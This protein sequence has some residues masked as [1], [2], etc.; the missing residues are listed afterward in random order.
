MLWFNILISFFYFS[1]IEININIFTQIAN[2]TFSSSFATT[3]AFFSAVFLALEVVVLLL[4]FL[5][6]KEEMIKPEWMRDYAFTATIYLLRT[7]FKTITKYFWFISCIKK[8]L[9]AMM[10][11]VFYKNPLAAIVAVCSVHIVYLGLAIYC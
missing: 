4:L 9:L 7:N 3:G 8:I 2:L 5:K 6:A 1:L 11:T 10:I